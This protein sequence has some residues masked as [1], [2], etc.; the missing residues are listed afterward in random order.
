MPL[1]HL[2]LALSVVF[3][4]GTNFVVIKWALADL[5]PFLFA[6]L[7]F[8][9]CVLPWVAF[10]KRPSTSWATMAGVG[11]LI[12]VG[13]F[14]LVYWAMR[15]DITAGLASLVVQAQ[16]FFTIA[17]TAFFKGER[18]SV[19]QWAALALAA[20]GYGVVAW[21]SAV[22]PDTS[23]TPFGVAL[24]LCGGMSWAVANILVRR[25]GRID[26]LALMVWSSAFAVPPLLA[27]SLLFE[28]PATVVHALAGAGPQAWAAVLWQAVGNTLYGFG[29]WNWLQARHPAATVT[30]LALLIPIFGMMASAV[31]LGE[32]LPGWKLAAAGLVMGGLALNVYAGRLAQLPR[33]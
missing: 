3:I 12:G 8:A 14:G 31:L 25:A 4:W 13:Q 11:L 33:P 6:T 28:G 9:L 32:A 23:V 1:T 29:A 22:D 16:V 5:P 18:P 30:P 15:A 2:L 21:G 17:L 24:V 26:M 19:P 20:V 7:R 10:V 27:I